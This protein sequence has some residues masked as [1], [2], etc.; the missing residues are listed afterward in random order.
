[1][2]SK[3]EINQDQIE[4]FNGNG[5]LVVENIIEPTQ[6][7]K[8]T[9]M[10]DR[11]LSGDIDTGKN[12]SDL[13]IGLGNS[14]AVENITQIMWPS[15]FLAELLSMPYHV[16]TKE[17]ARQIYGDD[18]E[19]DFDMLINKAPNTN[20]PTPW[21]QDA[22]YWIN[23]PDKRALSCWLALDSAK[24]DNGC[25]WY[26]PGSHLKPLR[27]H[28]FAGKVGGALMCECSE[29]EGLYVEL[30]PGSCILHHGGTLHYSRG[31]STDLM[32]RALV[33][34]FRPAAMIDLERTV[35]FDHG[36]SGNSAERTVK[37]DDF[38]SY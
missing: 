26:V 18:M 30:G 9:E 12:R 28:T 36:R 17:I 5:Y 10:Y 38:K 2:K 27:A 34:N 23:M 6:V 7:E 16:N 37:N 1:M 24:K 11:F 29:E 20:T 15:D 25:M 14:E 8:Y 22:A 13:G 33:T 3:F 31:N 4:F 21:H 19:L 32:R 35:G